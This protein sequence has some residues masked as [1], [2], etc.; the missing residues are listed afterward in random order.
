MAGCSHLWSLRWLQRFSPSLVAN[1]RSTHPPESY[2][3]HRKKFLW[4]CTSYTPPKWYPAFL[5]GPGLLQNHS[6]APLGCFHA[7]N[8]VHLPSSELQNPSFRTQ[9][10]PA[11]CMSISSWGALGRGMI[12]VV[13][14]LLCSPQTGGCTFLWGFEAPFCLSWSPH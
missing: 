12:C 5:V 10:P 4:W 8:P 14:P 1:T 9:T 6:L 7:A 2:N 13:I 3:V 11:P